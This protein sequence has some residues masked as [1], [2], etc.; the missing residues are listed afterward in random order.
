MRKAIVLA[1]AVAAFAAVPPVSPREALAQ[2]KSD[3][4]EL[5]VTRGMHQQ[6][7]FERDVARVAVGDEKI[8]STQ[9][10]NSRTILLLGKETGRT[11]LLVWYADE[12]MQ[13]RIVS[14][15]P[16]YELLRRALREIHPNIVVDVAPDRAAVVLRGV[17][18][19][20]SISRAAESA[21]GAYLRSGRGAKAPVVTTDPGTV[22]APAAGA[23]GASDQNSVD[24]AVINL[25]RVERLPVSAE[26]RVQAALASIGAPEVRVERMV[27][28]ES[29][30]DAVD[31]LLLRGRVRDQIQLT[32]TLTVAAMMYLGSSDPDLEIKVG[33][34]EAGG[35]LAGVSG[36]SRGSNRRSSSSNTSASGSNAGSLG[37]SFTLENEIA[38]NPGRAKLI[39]IGKGRIV[40]MLDV[41]DVPQVRVG[42]RI[43]EV[44]RTAL[45]QFAPELTTIWSD[46]NQPGLSPSSGAIGVQGSAN[47]ARVGPSS[48]QDVQGVLSF[49]EDGLTQEFQYAGSHF[50]VDAIFS[51]LESR[52]I[53]RALASPSLTVLSGEDANFQVGGEIPIPEA[54]SPAFGSEATAGN[55]TPGVFSS[56]EFRR[57]GVGLAIR[58]LV[59]EG[60]RVTIDILSNVDQPD[61]TLTTLIRDSTGTDPATTAFQTRR[62]ET[63]TRLEDGQSLL[64]GGLISRRSSDSTS[65][66]PVLEK[67]PGLGWLF[68]RFAVTN[69]DSEIVIVINP[70]ILRDPIPDLGMWEN[71]DLRPGLRH[72][73]RRMIDYSGGP[74]AGGR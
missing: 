20:V 34:D 41:D 68:K 17:V 63:T 42:V 62:I 9:V 74:R 44:N 23:K 67:I 2:E 36:S 26:A 7:T 59:G 37:S 14:V 21:A 33:A 1:F 45:L 30:D 55:T 38:S 57:F 5:R 47:A 46:F 35:L 58:P 4:A 24:G 31:I 61:E 70:S 13:P 16:D 40:A 56:V 27:R 69:D 11:S 71:P 8:L 25:I 65:L 54:F 52:S 6:V 28:G 39:S 18:P 51:I 53:A 10:L 19:D 32:R 64:I 15:E 29:P 72:W 73:I 48:T 12:T 22:L 3:A 43:Y 50:A 66:T 49:L 60:G